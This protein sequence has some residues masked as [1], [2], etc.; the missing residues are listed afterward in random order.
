MTTPALIQASDT[1]DFVPDAHLLGIRDVLYKIAGIF[2]PD[3]KLQMLEACCMVRMEELGIG[4]L[5]DYFDY[6]TA[7]SRG[8]AET[9]LLLNEILDNDTCFFRGK[10]QLDA[11][12]KIILPKLIATKFKSPSRTIKIWSAGCSTG[13]EAYTLAITLL[14]EASDL[15]EGWTCTILASDIDEQAVEHARKAVYSADAIRNLAP[16]I[17]QKYFVKQGNAFSLCLEA[18]DLISFQHLNLL[19]KRRVSSVTNIDI[20]FCRNVLVYLDN[21]AKAQVLEHFHNSLSP[22][23]ILFLDPEESLFAVTSKFSLVHLPS[24]TAYKKIENQMAGS[25]MP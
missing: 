5:R 3:Q 9:T 13:E 2:P 12:H 23:G 6:L 7:T 16:D 20:I 22:G 25:P 19:D 15:L 8:R 24:A 11:L 4:L 17:R 1:R 18:R 14:E 21:L 10:P